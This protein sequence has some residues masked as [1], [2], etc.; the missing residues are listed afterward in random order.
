MHN[1]KNKLLKLLSTKDTVMVE[2]GCLHGIST[3][4]F[5]HYAKTVHTIDHYH[6]PYRIRKYVNIIYHK[7]A[8]ARM[9]PKIQHLYPDKVDLAYID[10]NHKYEKV[11]E[12]IE[13]VLPLIKN[14]GHIAGHDYVD[15]EYSGVIQA[16]RDK[17]KV[18]PEVFEDASWIIKMSDL[19]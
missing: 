6:D 19:K 9:L 11:C 13:M 10:G 7:G 2:L 14:T 5:A 17:L 3:C 18:E 16:I 12:D 4:L 15:L 8:F 1:H